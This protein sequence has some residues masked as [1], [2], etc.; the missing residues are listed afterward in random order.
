MDELAPRQI[1]TLRFIQRTLEER[2]YPPTYREIGQALGIHSTNGVADHVKA[3]VK[4]G[5]LRKPE[6]GAAR[7]IQ[8]T[9]RSS[10]V[11]DSPMVQVPVLGMV[12]AGSP[13]LAEENING[14]LALGREMVP[15][16]G[17]VFA[18][19]VRGE[20]MIEEGIHDGDYVIVRQ[21][22]TARNGDMVVALID[23]EATVK[24]YFHE[25]SR[26]RLQPAHPTMAPIFI[27]PNQQ[28]AIQ[29]KVVAVFRR[30]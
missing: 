27:R 15:G 16:S 11:V 3:L 29:G 7:G 24:F 12:A 19:K 13:I 14:Q 10:Q 4:K 1:E 25:G 17:P 18:L 28:A 30:Y 6:A 26:I 20:S 5:Y 21:Q 23:D 8:L 2:G 22:Q 9:A